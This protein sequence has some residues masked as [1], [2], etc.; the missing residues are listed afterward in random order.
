MF[1]SILDDMRLSVNLARDQHFVQ[2]AK[3]VVASLPVLHQ[4]KIGI[5]NDPDTRY[6]MAHYAYAREHVQQSHKTRFQGMIIMYVHQSRDVAAMMEHSL[7]DHFKTTM[8][9]RCLNAKQDFDNHIEYDSG[10]SED[11]DS[12]GPVAVYVVHG[13]RIYN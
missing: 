1:M 4:F 8:P 2:H 11:Y 6:Y 5:T 3:V 13:E 10:D 9:T 12:P 7:I